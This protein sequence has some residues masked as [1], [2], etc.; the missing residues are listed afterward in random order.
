MNN[1]EKLNILHA[2]KKQ[3]ER[4]I[5]QLETDH[6]DAV[7]NARRFEDRECYGDGFREQA[8]KSVAFY[9]DRLNAARL[10]HKQLHLRIE[11]VKREQTADAALVAAYGY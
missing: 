7:K 8:A 10:R 4:D 3:C 11:A 6:A 5:A 9:G 1:T 2:E